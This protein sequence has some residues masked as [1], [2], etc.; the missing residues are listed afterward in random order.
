VIEGVFRNITAV[1]ACRIAI[2]DVLQGATNLGFM[3]MPNYRGW[4]VVAS[5]VVCL[6]HLG[7]HRATSLG[8]TSARGDRK[9]AAGAGLRRQRAARD[10]A[11]LRRFGVA[12]AA[13]AGV[14]A[15]PIY[16]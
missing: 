6:Q 4:V 12:L 3:Y 13:L 5:L 15:A 7:H 2:P 1:P 10:H 8:A 16:R 11:D 9:P 14:L